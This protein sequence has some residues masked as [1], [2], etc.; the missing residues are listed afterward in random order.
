MWNCVADDLP[1]NSTSGSDMGAAAAYGDVSESNRN[2]KQKKRGVFS[3][4]ATN[5]LR[6]W[7]FQ[8]LAV[9]QPHVVL[10]VDHNQ[11]KR[12]G[13]I[14]MSRTCDVNPVTS[15]HPGSRADVRCSRGIDV[16]GSVQYREWSSVLLYS[17][18][19]KTCSLRE[20]GFRFGL[21]DI[22][23]RFVVMAIG[24]NLL[25]YDVNIRLL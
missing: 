6:A 15:Q 3:K 1:P 8:H 18:V 24:R 14:I 22:G 5:V 10:C 4:L 19:V 20:E 21:R 9:I 25:F 2:M 17:N 16:A 13:I 7:L 12:R 23:L 11:T